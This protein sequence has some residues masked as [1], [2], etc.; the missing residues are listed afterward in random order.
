MVYSSRGTNRDPGVTV[1][2][3]FGSSEAHDTDGD[4]TDGD[5]P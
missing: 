2:W 3:V 4:D 5:V 1:I